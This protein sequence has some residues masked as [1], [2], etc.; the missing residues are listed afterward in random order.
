M[1]ALSQKGVKAKDEA[2]WKGN[3]LLAMPDCQ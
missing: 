1:V 2:E 3:L